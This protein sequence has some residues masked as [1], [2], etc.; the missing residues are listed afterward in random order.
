MW[1][2]LK[3]CAP[4]TGEGEEQGCDIRPQGD[5]EETHRGEPP[6]GAHPL[7]EKH[8]GRGLLTL[9]RQVSPSANCRLPCQDVLTVNIP[10]RRRV[11]L[12]ESPSVQHQAITVDI[13]QKNVLNYISYSHLKQTFKASCITEAQWCEMETGF[14]EQFSTATW[15]SFIWARRM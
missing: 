3:P 9:H 11:W 1:P 2:E 6:G 14:M 13:Q 8:P 5:E 12:R 4:T 7:R 10:V 15:L